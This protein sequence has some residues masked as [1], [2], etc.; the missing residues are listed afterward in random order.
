VDAPGAAV[1]DAVVLGDLA[2]LA[3]T[4]ADVAVADFA[5]TFAA[6]VDSPVFND[7]EVSAVVAALAADVVFSAELVTLPPSWVAEA[8]APSILSVVLP[9]TLAA[10]LVFEPRESLRLPCELRP[11]APP[12]LLEPPRPPPKP[13]PSPPA[14]PKR[15][16]YAGEVNA[17]TAAATVPANICLL[18]MSCSCVPA[19]IPRPSLLIRRDRQ[20]SSIRENI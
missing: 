9:A 6:D 3:D 14:P 11:P 18:F 2:A 17:N 15:P 7:F 1:V 10:G 4:G 8:A 12:N 16:A 5:G 20:V 13:P 19:D